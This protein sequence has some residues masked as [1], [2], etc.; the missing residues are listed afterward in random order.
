MDIG[1]RVEPLW[2]K[3]GRYQ[4]TRRDACTRVG[5]IEL[6]VHD[7]EVRFAVG[8]GAWEDG[9]RLAEAVERILRVCRGDNGA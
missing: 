5:E 7:S 6:V 8:E 2:N 3:F 4:D 1:A 9:F